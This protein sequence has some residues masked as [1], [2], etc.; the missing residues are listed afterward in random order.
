[1]PC[2][3]RAKIEEYD[4]SFKPS[5]TRGQ[6]VHPASTAVVLQSRKRSEEEK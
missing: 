5:N 2:E 1:M 3:A 4:V 6:V